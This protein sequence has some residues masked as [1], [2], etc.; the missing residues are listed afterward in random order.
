MSSRPAIVFEDVKKSYIVSDARLQGFKDIVINFPRY[1]KSLRARGEYEALKGVSFKVEKGECFGIIGRNGSGKST[2]LGLIAGVLKAGGGRVEVAHRVSPLLELG[3]GFHPQLTGADNVI[4]NGVLLGMTRK[5]VEEKYDD[6][7][8]F[9]ELGDFID[10]PLLTYSSGMV[11]RLGFSVVVHLEPRILLIDETLSVGD[12]RF[13]KKCIRKMEEFRDRGITMVFVSHDLEAVRRICD[14]VA[15][16]EKGVIQ[17]EG[18]PAGVVAEYLKTLQ[19][20][21]DG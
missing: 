4:L 21:G 5:Q 20:N 14:R 16:L 6:I 7:V 1:L 9:A 11:A 10:R 3:A 2:I 18:E 13:Q 15:L 19:I 12:E 8:E 17:A